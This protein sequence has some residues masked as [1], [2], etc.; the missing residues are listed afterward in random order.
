MIPAVGARNLALQGGALAARKILPR[1]GIGA[2]EGAVGGASGASDMTG[3]GPNAGNMA[4]GAVFGAVGG[5]IAEPIGL[6][7]AKLVREYRKFKVDM[8]KP[9]PPLMSRISNATKDVRSG[10]KQEI[11]KIRSEYANIK[12]Q[13]ING[14]RSNIKKFSGDLD[15]ATKGTVEDLQ[16][17]LP[18]FFKA[19]SDAYGKRFDEIADDAANAGKFMRRKDVLEILDNTEA[20]LD[21]L[22]IK[23]SLAQKA[24]AEL[25]ARFSGS[26]EQG[27]IIL[28]KGVGV[29]ALVDEK[30]PLKEIVEQHKNLRKSFSSAF[31]NGTSGYSREDIPM[32]IL[33]RNLA[34]KI[35]D[36]APELKDL[37]AAYAPVIKARERAYQI[38]KPFKGDVNIGTGMTA[39]R[40]QALGGLKNDNLM[41]VIEG[42]TEFSKGLGPVTSRVDELGMQIKALKESLSTKAQSIEAAKKTAVNAVTNKSAKRLGDL[43]TRKRKVQGLLDKKKEINELERRL[44]GAG[45]TAGG[46][47]SAGWGISQL[48][49]NR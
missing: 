19:N 10:A 5:A 48:L 27:N 40:Q 16:K 44:T 46:I 37:N 41:N 34:D 12:Q 49:R 33:Q 13:T 20:Q 31:R 24:M 4:T 32:N 22:E 14:I 30:I 29:D 8:K 9:L 42:G 15:S 1:M 43:E 17:K 21:G 26:L 3:A 45:L 2:I 23:D 7:G 6:G 35:A 28:P 39:L 18:G 11:D 47:T 25:R 38:F 36:V